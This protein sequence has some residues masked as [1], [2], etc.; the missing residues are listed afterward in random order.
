MPRS[1]PR[2]INLHLHFLPEEKSLLERA[3][4]AEGRSVGNFVRWY[5]L[6]SAKRVTNRGKR[7]ERRMVRP[8][9]TKESTMEASA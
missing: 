5:A 3:A 2:S 1:G 4:A 8:S 7:A 6:Q 9:E